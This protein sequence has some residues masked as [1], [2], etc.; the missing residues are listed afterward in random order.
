LRLK[1]IMSEFERIIADREIDEIVDAGSIG[2]LRTRELSLI[3]YQTYRRAGE[4]AAR[5]VCNLA[6]DAAEGLLSFCGNRG[7]KKQTQQR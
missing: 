2:G 7:A 1:S 3:A 5:C 6:G 4:G